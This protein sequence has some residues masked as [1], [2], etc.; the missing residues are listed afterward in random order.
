M[1]VDLNRLSEKL[2]RQKPVG[3]NRE[4]QLTEQNPD[5]D[6][7]RESRRG[8]TTLHPKRFFID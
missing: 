6:G 2:K 5:N 7:S 4:G 1:S 8:R 3:V